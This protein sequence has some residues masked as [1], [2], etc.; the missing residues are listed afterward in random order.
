MRLVIY[1]STAKEQ[2]DLEE[3]FRSSEYRV[4]TPGSFADDVKWFNSV[5]NAVLILSI[6]ST[7]V[8]GWRAPKETT[9]LFTGSIKDGPEKYQAMSRPKQL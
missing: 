5:D 4:P 8:T 9:V 3:A 1:T 2:L 6:K 7:A